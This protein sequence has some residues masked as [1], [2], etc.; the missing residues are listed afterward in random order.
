R[1]CLARLCL[2]RPPLRSGSH[3]PA[4]C[5][6]QRR[7]VLLAVDDPLKS[8]DAQA[9]AGAWRDALD[10]WTKVSM[11]SRAAEAARQYNMG[12]AHEVMAAIAM[13][14]WELNDATSHFYQSQE[15]YSQ[16]LS[17]DPEE[18]YF[19]D[20]MARL[21]ADQRLLQQQ[22]QQASDE[23]SARAGAGPGKPA[24]A[25]ASSLTAPV[26]GWPSGDSSPV[27]DYRVYAG[28]GNRIAVQD[29]GNG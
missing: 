20:T 6:T 16:A 22:L 29:P 15:C 11:R 12:V 13:G 21:Q 9:V 24:P 7:E 10:N 8:G 4:F 25:A 3:P 27:H 1:A 14:N 23:E 28:E 2:L 18:K 19:R 17:L 5:Y 26:D